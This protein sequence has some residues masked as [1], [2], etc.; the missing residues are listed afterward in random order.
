MTKKKKLSRRP[1]KQKQFYGIA[2]LYGNRFIDLPNDERKRL[3]QAKNT[4]VTC[5]YFQQM[6]ALGPQ[7][8]SINCN[9]TGGVCSLRNFHPLQAPGDDITFGP[10]TATCPNRFLENGTIIKHIG[11]ELLG[12]DSPL[13]AK[14]IPFLRRPLSALEAENAPNAKEVDMYAVEDEGIED[15]RQ[16]DVGRIDLVVVNPDDGT[17]WCAVEMQAVYFSGG[18]MTKDHNNILTF[19]GNGVPMPGA[20]RRPDF[21]SSGPKRLMPQLMIKVPTLRRW[22]K[23]MVVVIDR[24]FL[25]ALDDMEPIDHISNCDIVWVVVDYDE[26]EQACKAVLK[27]HKTIY[28][29]LE[30][31]VKGLT[32]GKPTTLPEFESKLERKLKRPVAK[33][34]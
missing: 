17:R 32:A 30:D 4:T 24:P 29:T 31:A 9:K 21:R 27:I 28:T 7:S 12:S 3:V 25:E 19:I 13:I 2:E 20:A 33:K 10:I 34:L 26:T 16:E 14:E 18:A 1:E 5:P 6:P 8:G 22:G 11:K 23:K 15:S